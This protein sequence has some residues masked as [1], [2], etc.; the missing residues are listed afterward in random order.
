MPPQQRQPQR[1]QQSQQMAY[2]LGKTIFFG[3]LKE[4]SGLEG[5]FVGLPSF[6]GQEPAQV[7][8]GWL[9]APPQQVSNLGKVLPY[10]STAHLK[11]SFSP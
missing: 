11:P 4:I 9:Q 8:P 6:S 5:G 3:F 10:Q 2:S 1:Q 7:L